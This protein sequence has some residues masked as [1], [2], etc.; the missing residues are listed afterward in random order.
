MHLRELAVGFIWLWNSAFAASQQHVQPHCMD[1]DFQRVLAALE[2]SLADNDSCGECFFIASQA[3][4]AS[5][6]HV[7]PTCVDLEFQRVLAA[8]ELSLVDND[9]CGECF[10][11]ASQRWHGLTPKQ[12]R[13]ICAAHPDTP[14][15]IARALKA[16]GSD[17]NPTNSKQIEW[18]VRALSSKCPDGLVI[19]NVP[20]W[21]AVWYRPQDSTVLLCM[22]DVAH[23][24]RKTHCMAYTQP[25]GSQVP[26]H[27]MDCVPWQCTVSAGASSPTLCASRCE[28]STAPRYTSIHISGI[29]DICGGMHAGPP[30]EE[31]LVQRLQEMGIPRFAAIEG[32]RHRPSDPDEAAMHALQIVSSTPNTRPNQRPRASSAPA[33]PVSVHSTPATEIALAEGDD[34][35]AYWS[36]ITPEDALGFAL[37]ACR[38][39][40]TAFCWFCC[41]RLWAST[42]ANAGANILDASSTWRRCSHILSARTCRPSCAARR[43][44]CHCSS[45][46]V[47]LRYSAC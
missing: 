35:P 30:V 34:V 47:L 16:P 36:P 43:H 3:F 29:T 27:F 41:W 20:A 2:L 11:I 18:V 6:Q 9:S 23:L 14:K 7:Q 32:A 40:S 8:L 44:Y 25:R 46:G 4:A 15:E 10:F 45:V 5:Q 17:E 24:P 12:A 21:Q 13:A 42:A 1:L 28:Q 19:L 31:S 39:S 37:P 22:Q 33:S 38:F 26:G